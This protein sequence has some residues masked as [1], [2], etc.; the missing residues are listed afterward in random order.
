M[1]RQTEKRTVM[2]K[3]TVAFRNLVNAAN[4]GE[5]WF[6]QCQTN[7][8]N[9]AIVSGQYI[10]HVYTYLCDLYRELIWYGWQ[11]RDLVI[12]KSIKENIEI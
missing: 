2:G 9:S 7:I 6:K 10:V 12:Y 1:E 4:D 11:W 3:I 8:G 5:E